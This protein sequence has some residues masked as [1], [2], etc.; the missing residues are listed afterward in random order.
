MSRNKFCTNPIKLISALALGRPKE[1]Q[2]PSELA[3]GGLGLYLS[4]HAI[5]YIISYHII[6]YHII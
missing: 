5:S 4:Y 2:R 3:V 1:E 6:S